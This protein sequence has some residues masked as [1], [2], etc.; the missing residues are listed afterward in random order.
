MAALGG[1]LSTTSIA[2]TADLT[3]HESDTTSVHGVADTSTLYRSGGTDVAVADGGTGSSTASAARTALGVVNDPWTEII[4]SV[5]QDVTNSAVLVDDT[6]LKFTAVNGG[7][8]HVEVF[9]LMSADDA[10]GDYKYEIALPTAS[11]WRRNI[12]NYG[13]GANTLQNSTGVQLDSATSMFGGGVQEGGD[14]GATI[15]TAYFEMMFLAGAA[16]DFKWQFAQFTQ[17]AAKKATTRAGSVLRYR[18]LA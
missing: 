11:G 15:R 1:T 10:T 8:Y 9:A 16:A 14:A 2:T 12:A 4:K 18:R 13:G 7:L 17:T 3:T 5:D 6:E